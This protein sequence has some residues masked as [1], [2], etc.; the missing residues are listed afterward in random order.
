MQEITDDQ[1]LAVDYFHDFLEFLKSVSQK[2]MQRTATGNISLSEIANLSKTFRQGKQLLFLNEEYGWKVRSEMDCQ[3]LHQIRVTTEVM[4]LIYKRKGEFHL[5]KNGL[6][7]LANISPAQQYEAMVLWFWNRVNWDYFS[8]G[9]I[10]KILQRDQRQIWVNLLRAGNEWLEFK[11][12]CQALKFY[13]HLEQYYK[14]DDPSKDFHLYL[15]VR[16][17]LLMR[18]LVR[19]GCVE[20]QVKKGKS[21]WDDEL[22]QF[23]S[24]DLGLHLY[25]LGLEPF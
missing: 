13:L 21:S 1:V 5:S 6:A 18:N 17:G 24:T 15:D 19:F 9:K 25:K 7:Y 2:P 16:S 20:T 23:R 12:F 14:G 8:L 4:Y 10:T 22:I 11:P 3:Y